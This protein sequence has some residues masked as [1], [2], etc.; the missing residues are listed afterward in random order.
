MH[1]NAPLLIAETRVQ[2]DA[3]VDRGRWPCAMLLTVENQPCRLVRPFIGRF[4]KKKRFREGA[5]RLIGRLDG[6]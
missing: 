6:P 2:F 4:E 1:D 3:V 5:R